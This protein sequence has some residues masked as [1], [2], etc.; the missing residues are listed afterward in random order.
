MLTITRILIAVLCFLAVPL[1][2]SAVLWLL[3][4][5]RILVF[6]L[7]VVYASTAFGQLREGTKGKKKPANPL[8][9][10]AAATKQAEPDWKS[11]PGGKPPMR[12]QRLEEAIRKE[13]ADDKAEQERL[14][15]MLAK[16]EDNLRK[17]KE[18]ERLRKE[19]YDDAGELPVTKENAQKYAKAAMMYQDGFGIRKETETQIRYTK[20]MISD[21]KKRQERL[22]GYLVK[23]EQPTQP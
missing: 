17:A 1:V 4:R 9:Q 15:K 16:I 19:D 23:D 3:Q 18:L 8:R 5:S 13:I 2:F 7:L 6:L 11:Y 20:A 12:E 10:P 22:A 21:L 14:E